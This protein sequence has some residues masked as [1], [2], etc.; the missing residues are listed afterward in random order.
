MYSSTVLIVASCYMPRNNILNGS[1]PYMAPI[2]TQYKN[3]N[4]QSSLIQ[5]NIQTTNINNKQN[6]HISKLYNY[7]IMTKLYLSVID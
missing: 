5:T 4:R 7:I 1:T 2:H 6:V 3:N